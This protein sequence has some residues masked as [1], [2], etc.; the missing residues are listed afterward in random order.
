VRGLED[1][2]RGP[3]IQLELIAFGPRAIESLAAFLLGPPAQHPQPRMLAAEALGAI[4]G[5]GAVDALVRALL[6]GNVRSLSL[7]LRMSEEAVRN[8][9]VR[10]L[11]RLGDRTA[12]PPLLEALERFHLVEA[13]RALAALHEPRAL[14]LLVE[15]L[16][17]PFIKT[18]SADAIL[19]F[20]DAA[21]DVRLDGLGRREVDDGIEVRGSIEV[22]QECAR[23]LGE[24]GNGRAE[25]RLR[26]HLH[27]PEPRVGVAVA[28]AVTRLAP[29][30]VG[31]D[32]VALLVEG[33]RSE[34]W[35]V[36]D[37]HADALATLGPRVVEQLT[38]AFT[39][40]A[41]QAD[42]RAEPAPPP[43]LRLIARTLARLGERGLAVLV[44][45]TQHPSPLARGVAVGTLAWA[46]SERAWPAIPEA[47]HDPDRRV[48][49]T[50]RACRDRLWRHPDGR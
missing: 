35:L 11:G 37:D 17:D 42:A 5:A 39:L 26:R 1:L 15:C 4:G 12:I 24:L 3:A 45:F 23:L 22:R 40:E 32:V 46:D 16:G 33:F 43:V 10:E 9:I 47:L 38:A 44:A 25:P 41:S 27:D 49:R 29:D 13:G 18:R 30:T 20:G 19:E 8:T 36:A 31:D 28:L 6:A 48:R 34:D 21:V 2:D 50:A 7:G 14:P